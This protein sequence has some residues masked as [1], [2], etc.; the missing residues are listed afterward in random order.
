MRIVQ[1]PVTEED[2]KTLRY[3]DHMAGLTGT[4]QTIYAA[5]EVAVQVDKETMSKVT[6]DVH[7]TAVERMREKFLGS[8]SDEQRKQLAPEEINFGAH[9]VLL[10]RMADLEQV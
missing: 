2:R 4:I 9:Y 7:N 3:F 6:R 10:C 8:V 1:R 5:D